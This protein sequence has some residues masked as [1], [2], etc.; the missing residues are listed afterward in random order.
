MDSYTSTV[1]AELTGIP[2]AAKELSHRNITD[3][4]VETADKHYQPLTDHASRKL[5]DSI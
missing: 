2:I 1:H 5:S 4:N 3:R